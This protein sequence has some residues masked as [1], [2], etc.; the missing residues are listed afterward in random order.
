MATSRILRSFAL[1][2]VSLLCLLTGIYYAVKFHK[3]PLL[4][5]DVPFHLSYQKIGTVRHSGSLARYDTDLWNHAVQVC[6]GVIVATTLVAFQ[7]HRNARQ[8]ERTAQPTSS[9]PSSRRLP[10][11]PT[12]SIPDVITILACMSLGVRV[13]SGL[14]GIHLATWTTT[15]PI[16]AVS[17]AV[18]TAELT[19][20]PAATPWDMSTVMLRSAFERV[21][22]QKAHGWEVTNLLSTFLPLFS[23]RGLQRTPGS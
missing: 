3:K 22:S 6:G 21:V 11:S 1:N 13:F 18:I 23:C 2:T 7:R 8:T 15:S 19:R 14:F 17:T 16:R 10:I 9:G 4:A 5:W 20:V 12:S